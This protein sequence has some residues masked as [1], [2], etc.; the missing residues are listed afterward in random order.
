MAGK[1]N[2]RKNWFVVLEAFTAHPVIILP[3]IIIAFFEALALEIIYFIPRKPLLLIAG[4]IV[5]KFFGENYLHYPVNLL[6]LPQ[7]FYYAQVLIFI[8]LSVFL[9]SI[10]INMFKNFKARLPVKTNALVRNAVERY[11]SL[12]FYGVFFMTAMLI[13]KE[14]DGFVFV[15]AAHLLENR[16]QLL[17]FKLA[18]VATAILMFITQAVLQV[19]LVFTVPMIVFQR[20]TFFR[21]LGGSMYLG[22]ANF[23]TVFK[24]I[25]LPFMIYLPSV[26]LKTALPALIDKAFPEISI[27]IAVLGSVTAIFADSF[28]LIS[29]SEFLGDKIESKT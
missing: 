12:F 11:F 3:F 24:L 28:I 6:I 4:P 16:A 25:L 2:I 23:G 29:A 1:Y 9:W 27:L 14:L 8:F 17:V 19:F 21:A 5:R 13:L 10:S 22:A 18:P 7:F 20:K 26:L 15:K